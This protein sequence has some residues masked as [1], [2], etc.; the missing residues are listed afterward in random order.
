MAQDL[1]R[2]RPTEVDLLNGAVVEE[3]AARGLAA[4]ANVAI[5]ARLHARSAASRAGE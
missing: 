2:G 3:A 5:I 1:A 4:P